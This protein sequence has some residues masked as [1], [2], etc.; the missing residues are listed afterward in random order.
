MKD[1]RNLTFK[2]VEEKVID[3]IGENLWLYAR[4]TINL[5]GLVESCNSVEQV[6]EEIQDMVITDIINQENQKNE[7]SRK[8]DE[9]VNP[10]G[11]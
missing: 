8:K 1:F 6:A 10:V 7:A 3:L 5:K 11:S 4:Y 2:E 9:R